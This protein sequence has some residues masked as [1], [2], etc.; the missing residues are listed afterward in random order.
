MRTTE[1]MRGKWQ[2]LE[3]RWAEMKEYMKL[4]EAEELVVLRR[5]F[6]YNGVE[7]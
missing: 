7:K 4:S 5:E 6:G 2:E 3:K 1:A